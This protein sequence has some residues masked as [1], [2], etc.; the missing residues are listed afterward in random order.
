M[1]DQE[2]PSPLT[3]EATPSQQPRTVYRCTYVLTRGARNGQACGRYVGVR[4]TDDGPRCPQHAPKPVA[5]DAPKPSKPPVTTLRSIE[6]AERLAAWAAV[7]VASGRI[8]P[9]AA[10]AAVNACRE[11]RRSHG[12]ASSITETSAAV[13]AAATAWDYIK[14]LEVV[15]PATPKLD[16]VR[17]IAAEKW[18]TMRDV[19]GIS[20]ADVLDSIQEPK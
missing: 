7:K 10:N 4:I 19:L 20:N 9:Q 2:Q 16:A 5:P 1:Q 8:T 13:Q 14:A 12:L 6:D 11:F 15:T 18:N 17:A 3:A